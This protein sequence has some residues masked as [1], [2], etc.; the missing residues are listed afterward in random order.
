MRRPTQHHNTPTIQSAWVHP[1]AGVPALGVF[2]NDGGDPPAGGAPSPQDPPKPGPPAQRTFTQDDLTALAAKEKAQ[3]E[4]AGARA[5]LE[6]VAADL[7][8]SNLDDAKAFIEEGR[9]AKE[10]RLSEQEKKERDLADREARADARE[11]AAAERERIANRRAILVGLGATGVDLEDA[12]A[13]LRVPDDADDTTITEAAEALKG[14][15]GEL[16]GAARTAADPSAQTP[17]LPPAPSGAPAGGPPARQTPTGKPGDRGRE[18][19]RL[20]GHKPAA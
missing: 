15:R 13:L 14:R 2:Y 9:K 17:Q 20:R 11:K 10:A 12:V 8:F 6:K 7:G 16:F 5:A 1:Y 3:G 4:R 18:M 19:A